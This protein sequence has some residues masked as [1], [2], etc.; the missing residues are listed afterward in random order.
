M[1]D[2]GI[3]AVLPAHNSATTIRR[4]VQSVM[5][6]S[7]PVSEIIVVDDHSTDAT[8][9]VVR[10][11]AAEDDR[12]SLV[13]ASDRGAGHA[14]NLG[15]RA[16][17]SDLIAFLDADDVW[18]PDKVET[19]LPLL[20]DDVAFVGA[21]VH[22]LSEDGAV[23]GSYLPFDDW[24]EATSSLRKGESM[25][26][27][28]AFALMRRATFLAA[29]GMDESFMRSQDLE[30]AQR[31]V[32]DGSRRVVWPH[33]RALGGY[34]L[35]ENGVSARSYRE[36][37]LAA[38]LVRARLQ[39]RTDATY[40]E[41]QRQPSLTPAAAR[42]LKSGHHYRRAAVA[43]G[44]GDLAKVVG[45]GVMALAHDPRGTARKLAGRSG[46]R[47]RLVPEEPPATVRAVF[48]ETAL[49]DPG[50][51][52]GVASVDVAG[53]RLAEDPDELGRVAA[54]DYRRDRRTLV[55]L[56]A[57]VTALNSVSDPGFVSAFRSAD[58]GYVDG[59]SWSVLA[60]LGGQRARKAATSDLAPRIIERLARQQGRAVT[61]AVLGGLPGHGSTP[62]VAAKAGAW[63]EASLPV[64]VVAVEHGYHD[65]W[66][67]ILGAVR[68]TDPDVVLVGLGMPLE[69]FWV[70]AHRRLLPSSLVITCGGWLRILAGEEDRA[71][72]PMCR[73]GLEWL[74]R[75]VTDPRRTTHRYGVGTGN[76]ARHGWSAARSRWLNHA[77]G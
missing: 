73:L 26:V 65:D 69:A 72:R 1:H 53:L 68:A 14:R 52:D 59:L 60:R 29:G 51:V 42:A 46:H 25:P 2:P 62:S 19:Q 47:G 74:H 6:Q 48:R 44:G 7:H 9:D 17:S 45:H 21:L 66:R 27:S 56:A 71:P 38:E 16:A 67:P 70:E 49:Q 76:L 50:S 5:A 43:M 18:Y 32:A 63:L 37:F 75:L 35:H 39:G 77:D 54:D 23:L 31:L 40:D 10:E 64:R 3:T 22:Y 13:A 11:L 33:D 24:D 34:V 41:W 20:S 15:V 55:L 4:A 8:P 30:L 58:A 57:H 61:V 36:Q 28:M 12:V